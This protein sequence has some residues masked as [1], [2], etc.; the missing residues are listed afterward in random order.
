MSDPDGEW[1]EHEERRRP[2]NWD[3]RSSNDDRPA[4]DDRAEEPT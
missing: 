2:T 1:A 4:Q 3:E